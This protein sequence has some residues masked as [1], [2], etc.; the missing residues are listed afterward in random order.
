MKRDFC[1]DMH[2]KTHVFK[3]EKCAGGK[4]SRSTVLVTA[5]MNREK[6]PLLVDSEEVLRYLAQIEHCVVQKSVSKK[7]KQLKI[8]DLFATKLMLCLQ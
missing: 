8:K 6:L 4:M 3:N 1:I 5:S 7:T 2:D